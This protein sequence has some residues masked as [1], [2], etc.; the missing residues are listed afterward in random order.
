VLQ[1]SRLQLFD[2]S[3]LIDLMSKKI[4]SVGILFILI[5][6]SREADAWIGLSPRLISTSG[7]GTAYHSDGSISQTGGNDFS[8]YFKKFVLAANIGVGY[9]EIH[10]GQVTLFVEITE[11]YDISTITYTAYTSPWRALTTSAAIGIRLYKN[12]DTSNEYN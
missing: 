10:L 6:I 2:F 9:Q 8:D 1:L 4:A 3:L 12:Q 7:N 11:S 5:L